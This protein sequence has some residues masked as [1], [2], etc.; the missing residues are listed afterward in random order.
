MQVEGGFSDEAIC[1]ADRRIVSVREGAKP[2]LA[3]EMDRLFGSRNGQNAPVP[4]IRVRNDAEALNVS[5]VRLA[6]PTH[7]WS[8]ALN[9]GSGTAV[10]EEKAGLLKNLSHEFAFPDVSG[11]DSVLVRISYSVAESFPSGLWWASYVPPPG[12][13]GG[14]L[15]A[16][17]RLRAPKDIESQ[18]QGTW[19]F[20]SRPIDG[21]EWEYEW[22]LPGDG[23]PDSE[24]F[25]DYDA[26]FVLVGKRTSWRIVG[27]GLRQLASEGCWETTD[28]EPTQRL[29]QKPEVNWVL[30][31]FRDLCAFQRESPASG[32]RPKPFSEVSS[33]RAG[34]CEDL[35]IVLAE[36]LN[37]QG[38][39][40]SLVYRAT[41]LPSLD[42]IIP[43]P[44][45]FDH[46]LVAVSAE[47]GTWMLDPF[48]GRQWYETQWQCGSKVETRG[49]L[50]IV[51]WR[52]K[53]LAN[54]SKVK[55]ENLP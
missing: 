2:V 8:W 1:L 24:D 52:S 11:N 5:W 23:C 9:A 13:H 45:L 31:V 51:P 26:P 48:A 43:C 27:Q 16:E 47:N 25:C 44:C 12:G 28:G 20:T 4:P 21:R 54:N 55:M 42:D 14:H 38:L 37:R 7:D 32:C 50:L 53:T 22:L 33:H 39:A 40:C 6:R 34:N 35:S 36:L 10:V 46:V 41:T 49:N 19:K 30:G 15:Y 29:V 18:V 17:F 3:I